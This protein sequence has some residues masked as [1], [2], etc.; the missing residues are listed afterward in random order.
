MIGLE[1]PVEPQEGREQGRDPQNCRPEPRQQI[2]VG[3]ERERHDRDQDQEEHDPNRRAAADAPRNAPLA[4]EQGERG[5]HL[6]P[7][8]PL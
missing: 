4:D 8:L 7:P 3:S 1:Q 2:E 6:T 5:G